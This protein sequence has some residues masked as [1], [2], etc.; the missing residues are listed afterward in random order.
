MN[1]K[2]FYFIGLFFVV[3]F[4][5]AYSLFTKREQILMSVIQKHI[6]TLEQKT[7]AD[8]SVGSAQMDG[9][10]RLI[11]SD[12]LLLTPTKDTLATVRKIK[13]S[14]NLS[15]LLRFSANVETLDVEGVRFFYNNPDGSKRYAFLLN[16]DADTASVEKSD[17]PSKIESF[18]HLYKEVLKYIPESMHLSDVLA[19]GYRNGKLCRLSFPENSLKNGLF[20][21]QIIYRLSS[22]DGRFTERSFVVTGDLNESDEGV[23][24]LRIYPTTPQSLPISFRRDEDVFSFSFDTMDVCF[25]TDKRCENW[26]GSFRFV[27]FSLTNERLASVPVCLDSMTFHYALN[28]MLEPSLRLELDSSSSLNVNGFH[29]NPYV[30][31]EKK[32][33]TPHLCV[34][35][36]RDSFEAQTLFDALPKG[37]FSNLE[38]M[39]TSG[40]LS[41]RLLFDL[42]MSQI[43]SL[44]FSSSMDKCDF[45]IV[46]QGKTDFTSVNRPF[47]Y[48]AYD[49]GEVDASFV[50][51]ETNPDFVHL[52]S[53]S[54]YL[55]H[56]IL[57]SE[58]GFFFSHKGFLETAMNAALVKDIKEH[59]FARGGSTISMQLVK[60]LWLSREK[61]L[62]RKMEEALIV[63]LVENN[64]LVSKSRMYEIYLNIIEWGPH[65]YG[66]RQASHF[67]FS[68]EPS[69]LTPEEAIFMA[70]I[71]PRP[72]KFMWF[73][74]N[75]RELKPFL[76]PYFDLLG[77][78]LLKHSIITQDQREKL[79]HSVDLTGAAR[80]YLRSSVAN[81]RPGD[82]A[83]VEDEAALMES[84]DKPREDNET[85]SNESDKKD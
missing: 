21:G 29:F 22:A 3:I 57:Y 31:Y 26:R 64:R 79:G 32:D 27:P 24:S 35:L 38:G 19:I 12:V 1:R 72:K 73:F 4:A 17:H 53:I 55:R 5:I 43:D 15:N 62:F 10:R 65:I 60:N 80:V 37:L 7:H 18:V 84:L 48:N 61:N 30:L 74:D 25:A 16:S 76:A 59:R 13:L 41:Y 44:K 40:K 39:E 67:Y 82:S 83:D 85:I 36:R 69:E 63:W 33:T 66:A 11:I 28:I 9:L 51:G 14:Y 34:K 46:Q 8:L 56:A 20:D 42:D 6:V 81:M 54:P 50:V 2:K 49:H 70:S 77:D 78:K 71:I 75:N 52:D 58:D 68:K 45:A 47:T 23:S